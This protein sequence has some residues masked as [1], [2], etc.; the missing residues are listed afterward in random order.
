M[1]N[2]R[3]VARLNGGDAATRDQ[4]ALE[5]ARLGAAV[6]PALR[7][8]LQ[9]VLTQEGRAA[10]EKLLTETTRPDPAAEEL[11]QVRAVE[12]LERMATSAAPHDAHG[13]P[14]GMIAESPSGPGQ[15]EAL[16]FESGRP[17]DSS[18]TE[19]GT[20]SH[21]RRISSWSM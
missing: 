12:A 18:G 8:S 6:E 13:E 4:A 11:R 5:L 16:F 20:R 17:R 7:Q 1:A 21:R 9:G 19:R 15:S 14:K 2:E 3:T 10:V